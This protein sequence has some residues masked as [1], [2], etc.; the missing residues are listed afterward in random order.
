M[1]K[2][3][4]RFHAIQGGKYLL[5]SI[6]ENGKFVY[7]RDLHGKKVKGSYNMLRHAGAIWA[8][9]TLNMAMPTETQNAVR[10]MMDKTYFTPTVAFLNCNGFG[11]L[12]GNSLAILAVSNAINGQAWGIQLKMLKESLDY[13]I[14]M[15]TGNTDLHKFN[16]DP[17]SGFEPSKFK[18]EYYPGEAA[19]ALA[20]LGLYDAAFKLVVNLRATRD[21]ETQLHDHWLAQALWILTKNASNNPQM[22]TIYME[23]ADRIGKTIMKERSH[24]MDRCTPLACRIEGLIPIYKM[25]R[26]IKTLE[27]IEDLCKK[28]VR[29]QNTDDK[30]KVFGAFKDKWGYRIDTT[31]HAISALWEYS[32][33]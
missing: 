26:D 12:G 17:K 20:T 7:L 5:K 16:L 1:E 27:F 11:K 21:K 30:S 8:L 9:N 31:Q 24:Y 33:L 14:N 25:T 4:A 3:A 2:K 18:S 10:Y 29:Y 15:R 13:F 23:Y 32:N 22:G 19:L 28:L 6:R